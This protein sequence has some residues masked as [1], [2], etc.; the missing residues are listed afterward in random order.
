MLFK[1][2]EYKERLKKVKDSMQK[3]G[4]DLLVSHDP[5]NMNYLTGYDA[6]SFYYAQCV[7]VHIHEDEPICFLRAQDAGGGYI[8]TY[9]QHK[10]IIAYDEKYI[11]TWPLHPYQYLVEIIKKNKWEKSTIG[12]EMDSHY[13]TAFCYETI[14]KGLPN[15][16][17]KDA[18]RLV[19][20]VRVVKS[21]AE[22]KLMQSAAKITEKGMKTAFEV[23]NPGVRQ[24]DAVGEIQKALFKGTPELGGDYASIA[25]LLPTGKGTSASHLTAT[26]DKFVTGE[27]TIIE[28]SGVHKRYHCPMARTV[29]LG[30]KNQKK[31]DTMKATNE[32]LDA[33]IAET[34]PGNTADDVAQ[35]FW[36][37]LDKYKIKKDSRTGY[38]IGI[39]YPPDWGEQTLNISKGDKTVLQPNVTFHMI[40]VMQFGDWG[41][42]ASESVRVTE[43]GSEL[44]CNL[45]REL[46]IKG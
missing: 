25:T 8:K 44:F 22:I 41:V 37:V 38:S 40:A 7:L 42:E 28:I 5:A 12:L 45:S 2:S 30:E 20:W 6:W 35:K 29:L 31:I 13:F 32:A 3:Q 43:K 15:A 17:I 21:D 34:K 10:N 33:G 18:E 39:G 1:N 27:A 46:H 19:N 23:I 16:K 11:H 4:I 14:K 24:C 9:V 26:E 36:K